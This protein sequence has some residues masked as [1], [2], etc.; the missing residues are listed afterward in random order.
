METSKKILIAGAGLVGSL[1]AIALKNRGH[2]V[3]I[4]ERRS[5]MRLDTTLA[6]KSINL[7]LTRKGIIP[8][9]KLGLLEKVLTITTPVFGRMMHDLA[10]NLTYQPYG[11]DE[12]E[13]N[14]SVPRG[15]LNKL[16]MTL[17]EAA[18]VE[19]YFN[20]AL[21]KLELENQMATFE[22]GSTER[23]D[24][25]FGADGAG[26]MTRQEILRLSPSAQAELIPLGVHYKEL[27][28]PKNQDGSYKIDEKAL[29][30]WP[31]GEHMLMAL[32]NNDGSFTMTVYLPEQ[33][34]ERFESA[35][36]VKAYFQ[37]YYSD[38]ISLM[39]DFA[40]EFL[41]NP[42]GFLG[43][44]E[45]NEWTYADK[46]CLIGDAAHAIVPFYGQGMNC[47]FSDVNFLLEQLEV[48][49]N[50]WSATFKNYQNH[51]KPNGDAIRDL[52]I[53][54][55]KVM[56]SKVADEKYLF[57]KKVENIIEKEMPE[58]YRSLYARVVYSDLPYHVAKS[59]A[60]EQSVL[61]DQLCE[62]LKQPEDVDLNRA[63]KLL[64]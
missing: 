62:G 61:I 34:F 45:M 31:R 23:F 3:M 18:G 44:L 28:M 52:S 57:R 42:Q 30:I 59:K 8:L 29:H 39:P 56:S 2:K 6:G 41:E 53:E 54:N 49:A 26:S 64:G 46:V 20:K 33:W 4:F 17:A 43:S 16:L 48:N 5:D 40:D 51:Q 21:K 9:E 14:Y 55:F 15:E 27:T 47:G 60:Q 22:D 58:L 25:F 10:G 24:F 36:D 1:L 32:P 50:D 37:E 12:S 7:I 63:R 38:A 11:R 19:I 35:T 13:K